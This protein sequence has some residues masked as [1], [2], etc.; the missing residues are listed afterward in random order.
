M[1]CR[2]LEADTIQVLKVYSVILNPGVADGQA[3]EAQTHS[4]SS[5]EAVLSVLEAFSALVQLSE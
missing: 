5:F 2:T 4:L 3:F 1:V